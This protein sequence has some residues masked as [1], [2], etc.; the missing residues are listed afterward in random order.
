MIL[1][2]PTIL[3]RAWSD[4]PFRILSCGCWV[5][6]LLRLKTSAAARR[7]QPEPIETNFPDALASEMKRAGPIQVCAVSPF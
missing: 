2:S 1:I 4:P 5:R 6:G 3:M 7:N